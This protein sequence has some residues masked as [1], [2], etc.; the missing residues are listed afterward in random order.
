ME[1]D[2]ALRLVSKLREGDWNPVWWTYKLKGDKRVVGD[3]DGGVEVVALVVGGEADPFRLDLRAVKM[4]KTW[5]LMSVDYSIAK[6]RRL[7]CGVPGMVTVFL[8]VTP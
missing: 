2:V 3:G 8:K 1:G 6:R 7:G 5:G 4:A